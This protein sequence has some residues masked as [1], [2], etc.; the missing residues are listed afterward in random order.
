MKTAILTIALFTATIFGF[1][2]TSFAAT[3]NGAGTSTVLPDVAGIDQIEVHG[4]VELYLSDGQADKVKVYSSYY[5]Q[6]ALVQDQNGVLR[7]SN[8]SKQKL[9]VWVTAKDLRNVNVY[10]NASVKSFGS[11]S[12]IDLDVRL[13]DHAFAKLNLDTF[14]ASITLNNRAKADLSG[15]VDKAVLRY[16]WS[17]FLN[18]R[19]LSAASI[20]KTVNFRHPEFNDQPELASL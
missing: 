7:L 13:F 4:N 18:T 9:V 17:S 1:N 16:D 12:F 19:N 15:S 8:Y 6:G 20:T 2:T 14:T 11:L 10:D 3:G 5:D